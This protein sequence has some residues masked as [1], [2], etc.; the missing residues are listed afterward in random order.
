MMDAY[1]KLAQD[2]QRYLQWPKIN[3]RD[4]HPISFS[5]FH[6]LEDTYEVTKEEVQS[7]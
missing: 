5:L 1:D 4:E 7:K 6:E 2:V 3:F